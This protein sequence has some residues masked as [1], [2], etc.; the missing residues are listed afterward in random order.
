MHH[1]MVVVLRFLFQHQRVELRQPENS[2]SGPLCNDCF[3]AF[4]VLALACRECVVFSVSA[5]TCRDRAAFFVSASTCDR[6]AFS[7]SASTCG[8]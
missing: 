4:S 6:A 2:I 5:S 1:C 3:A 8:G 7:V